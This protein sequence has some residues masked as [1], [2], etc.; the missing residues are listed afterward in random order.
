[1]VAMMPLIMIQLVGLLYQHKVTRG[2]NKHQQAITENDEEIIIFPRKKI[3]KE[4]ESQ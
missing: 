1:M 3:Q 4:G 2:A